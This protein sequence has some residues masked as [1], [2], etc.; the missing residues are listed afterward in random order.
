M[1][2]TIIDIPDKLFDNDNAESL[3]FS[4]TLDMPQLTSG[5]DV[6][7][8][9]APLDW[10]VLI[11]N[12]GDKQFLVTG[13]VSGRARGVCGRCLDEFDLPLTGEIEG[14]WLLKDPGENLPDDL[15]ED[16]FEV[17][18][19][20]HRMD[21]GPFIQ[22]ALVLALPFMP[23]CREDCKGLCPTC[24]KN[25]ND[26]PCD[27]K[28]EGVDDDGIDPNNPFAVLKGLDFPDN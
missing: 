2:G 7:T 14:Y 26:G 9:D 23:L 4:G 11:V 24:G 3:S 28:D 15:A 18:P 27:C 10:N 17:I 21:L 16:E 12:S 25:L 19:E 5:P 20:D 1:S 22:A 8:F 13:T 6:Y